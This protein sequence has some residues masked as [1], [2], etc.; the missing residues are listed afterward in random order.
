MI[1][2]L[3][4]GQSVSCEKDGKWLRAK[5]L[6]I[7]CS[8]VKILFIEENNTEWIYRGSTRYNAICSYLGVC[9]RELSVH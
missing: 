1:L 4:V 7:D 3:S 9:N 5:C 2:K 8:L 6:K